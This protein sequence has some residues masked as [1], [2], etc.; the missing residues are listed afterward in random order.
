MPIE[1]VVF[2]VMIRQ[3]DNWKRIT[4]TCIRRC[5]RLPKEQ[6]EEEKTQYSMLSLFTKFH[7]TSLLKGIL[8][9]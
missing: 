2:E 5:N 3:R 8:S 7:G 9:L 1:Y 6:G 4:I